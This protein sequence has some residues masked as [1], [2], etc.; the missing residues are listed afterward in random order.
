MFLLLTWKSFL[1]S[2][3]WGSHQHWRSLDVIVGSSV[4]RRCTLGVILISWSLLGRFTTVSC[5]SCLW[6]VESSTFRN[7]FITFFRLVDLI[8]F[9]THL[10]MNFFGSWHDVQHL[11]IFWLSSFNQ[12]FFMP[13]L[14]SASVIFWGINT[15]FHI[16]PFRLGYFFP[17]LIIKPSFKSCILC[18]LWQIFNDLKHLNVRKDNRKGITFQTTVYLITLNLMF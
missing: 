5:C 18:C 16:G 6:M 2:L 8:Y 14:R 9:L 1:S 7:G 12:I 17:P 10:F 15:F 13:R 3:W 11:R 4:S